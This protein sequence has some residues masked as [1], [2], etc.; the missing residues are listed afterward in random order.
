MAEALE[1]EVAFVLA[2]IVLRDKAQG[3]RRWTPPLI[4]AL[5]Y[6]RPGRGGMVLYALL[7]VVA[8]WLL[9][10]PVSPKMARITM[11]RMQWRAPNFPV[12]A[13]QQISPAMYD[14]SNR[15]LHHQEDLRLAGL[16]LFEETQ[17]NYFNHFP[18]RNLTWIER[19]QF[20]PLGIFGYYETKYQGMRLRSKYA[21]EPRPEGGWNVVWKESE[22]T[23]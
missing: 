8:G 23:P 22:F 18:V 9:M 3:M 7:L 20:Q 21:L 13:V 11:E 14:F 6:G 17:G 15:G 1:K 19:Y 10:M 4:K 5:A 16:T 12:W 2:L